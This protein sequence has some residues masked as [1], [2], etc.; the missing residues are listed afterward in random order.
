MYQSDDSVV[1]TG[2]I[3]LFRKTKPILRYDYT[4]WSSPVDNQK[5][6][7][8][9]PNTLFDK[10]LSFDTAGG[11]KEEPRL[12]NMLLGKGYAI[13]GPQEFSITSRAVYEAVFKGIPNN[14]KVEIELGETDS[15]GLVG[16]PYPSAIDAAIFLKK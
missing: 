14:G 1:N 6:I 7:D 12:N 13:R 10:Y 11:W 3:N 16:N 5:L 8:V 9:S 15:F 2:I 4:F